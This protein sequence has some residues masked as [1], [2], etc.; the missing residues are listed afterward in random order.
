MFSLYQTLTLKDFTVTYRWFFY[1]TNLNRMRVSFQNLE[2]SLEVQ[3]A[4]RKFSDNYGHNILEHGNVLINTR[5]TISKKTD[6]IQYSKLGIRLASRVPEN[7]K[8]QE[9]RKKGNIR[10]VLILGGDIF[11]CPIFLSKRK[12]RQSQS[13][14][15]QKQISDLS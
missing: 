5:L 15:M 2:S 1:R 14:D 8:T 3:R 9:H 10:K 12:F 13:K 7:F 6:D 4:K 11:Q